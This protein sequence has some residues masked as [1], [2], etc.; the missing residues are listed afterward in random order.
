MSAIAIISSNVASGDNISLPSTIQPYFQVQLTDLPDPSGYEFY[1]N[2]NIVKSGAWSFP[3]E[4]EARIPLTNLQAGTYKMYMVIGFLNGTQTITTNTVTLT[5]TSSSVSPQV[6]TS[7]GV[8][9]APQL[10][11]QMKYGIA[12]L[13]VVALGVGGYLAYTH[14]KK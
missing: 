3:E 13:V 9:Q 5:V 2:G 1:V 8:I 12:G 11:L 4:Y 10:S 7:N 6:V 14:F